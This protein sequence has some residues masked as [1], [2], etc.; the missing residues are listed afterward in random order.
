MVSL[1][2][3]LAAAHDGTLCAA[4]HQRLAIVEGDLER[5]QHEAVQRQRAERTLHPEDKQ[6]VLP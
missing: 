4:E 2:Y 3:Y 1:I 6:A 5:L